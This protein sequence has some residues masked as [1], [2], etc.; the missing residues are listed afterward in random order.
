[1]VAGATEYAARTSGEVE[2]GAA[3]PVVAGAFDGERALGWTCDGGSR[4]VAE[5]KQPDA[6]APDPDSK[7]QPSTMAAATENG[8]AGMAC[9]H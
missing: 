2:A 6:T 3:A 9:Y 8:S 5:G 4:E 1:M 7:D